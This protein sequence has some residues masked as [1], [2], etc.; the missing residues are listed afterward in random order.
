MITSGFI[1]EMA[2]YSRWQNDRIYQH[3]EEIGPEERNRDRSMFFG[4]I[5]NTL[6]H[7]CVVNHSILSFLDG[8]LPERRT[9]GQTAWPDW[10]ELK[11]ICIEQDI[12]LAAASSEWTEAWLA[13]KT[14]KLDLKDFDLPAIPRWVMVVQLF[15][16]QTHHRSRVTTALHA[17]GVDYGPTDIPWRP[18]AGY[19]AG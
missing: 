17:I 14:I 9:P 19:F 18:G 1:A 10:S 2:S 15:N 8:G 13:N 5:H 16:H 12:A 3:C 4:S 6:D 11:S 7:I